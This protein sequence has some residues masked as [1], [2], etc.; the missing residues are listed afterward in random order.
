MKYY[1]KL[2][3]VLLIITSVASGILAYINTKTQPIIDE[4]QR[5]EQ[6]KARREVLPLAVTFKEVSGELTYF[7]GHDK[8]EKVIGY[9]FIASLFGYSSEVKTM[10]GV[11]TGFDIENIKI[12]SQAETPGLGA[13]CEK[14]DFQKQFSGKQRSD[15][16]VDKDGGTIISLTG[17]TITSRTITNSIKTA[18]HK[19]KLE[20]EAEGAVK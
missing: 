7:I 4:N 2:G 9:T 16:I 17:A 10:V 1:L 18:L 14:L 13:N 15:M 5:M 20:T 8:D 3:F 11:N 6:E 12:I 19:I